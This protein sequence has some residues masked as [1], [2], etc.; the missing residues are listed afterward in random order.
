MGSGKGDEEANKELK[1]T[2]NLS[3]NRVTIP[4]RS[5]SGNDLL[6]QTVHRPSKL[7]LT[8]S[9][10]GHDSSTSAEV[11][12]FLE[13]QK[14]YG[15]RLYD[16]LDVKMICPT[17]P[18]NATDSVLK[19]PEPSNVGGSDVSE[20]YGVFSSVPETGLPSSLSTLTPTPTAGIFSFG[21]LPSSL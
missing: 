15:C 6:H 10:H 18:A 14:K 20:D 4:A 1:R 19:V 2:G 12:V 17:V 9:S 8:L 3:D 13:L 11:P 21:N 5:P 16:I 7:L